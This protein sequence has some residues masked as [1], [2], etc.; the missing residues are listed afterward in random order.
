MSSWP[1]C[2]NASIICILKVSCLSLLCL[3]VRC[4]VEGLVLGTEKGENLGVGEGGRVGG[5]LR[6]YGGRKEPG[7]GGAEMDWQDGVGKEG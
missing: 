7:R 1:R 5:P 4:G 3:F 2:R 6:E